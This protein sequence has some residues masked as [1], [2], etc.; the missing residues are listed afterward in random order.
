MKKIL[1]P[2]DFSPTSFDAVAYANAIALHTGAEIILFHAHSTFM[3]PSEVPA[4]QAEMTE[5]LPGK[6]F[7]NA[8]KLLDDSLEIRTLSKTGDAAVEILRLAEAENVDLI[9]MGTQGVTGLLD[10]LFGTVAASV[11][12]KADCPVIAIPE[13]AKFG[14]HGIRKILFATEMI[15]TD[16]WVLDQLEDFADK[17]NAQ[18]NGVCIL[19]ENDFSEAEVEELKAKHFTLGDLEVELYRA[20]DAET[21]L[22]DYLEKN[23]TDVVALITRRPT[24]LQRLLNPGLA[25][26]MVNYGD[27]PVFAFHK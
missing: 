21:G 2:V 15:Q 14:G 16:E 10:R 23:P 27:I 17:M 5:S 6:G 12:K 20:K 3:T 18:I 19:D 9:V 26:H 25:R 1:C 13:K 24:F 11:M 8:K 4:F 7:E 22:K